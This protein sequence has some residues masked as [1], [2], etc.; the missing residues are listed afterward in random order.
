[1]LWLKNALRCWNWSTDFL[2]QQSKE[3]SVRLVQSP[4]TTTPIYGGTSYGMYVTAPSTFSTL[5]SIQADVQD[6]CGSILNYR[7][8]FQTAESPDGCNGCSVSQRPSKTSTPSTT[9]N[10][11]SKSLEIQIFPNP[12]N[13]GFDIKMPLLSTAESK[14]IFT[15]TDMLGRTVQEGQLTNELTHLSTKSMGTGQYILKII[16]NS[17]V[18][19]KVVQVQH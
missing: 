18:E 11:T 14:L 3:L 4:Y 1:M 2:A 6:R 17:K 12:S 13:S 9:V 5:F 16:S 10:T 7:R 8:A 19:Q 15:L